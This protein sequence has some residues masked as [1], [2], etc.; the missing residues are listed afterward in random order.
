MLG[1]VQPVDHHRRD[2][3][4]GQVTGEQLGESESGLGGLDEPAGHR[5]PGRRPDG[6]LDRFAD[7]TLD[8]RRGPGEAASAIV[9]RCVLAKQWCWPDPVAQRRQRFFGFRFMVCRSEARPVS[10]AWK[11]WAVSVTAFC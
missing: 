6:G 3:Q 5:R 1:D 4:L 2:F 10:V 7:G 11:R 8:P 9:D